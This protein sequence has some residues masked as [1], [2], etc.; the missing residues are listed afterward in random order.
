MEVAKIS[1]FPNWMQEFR[2]P[3]PRWT[4]PDELKRPTPSPSINLA[5]VI[6]ASRNIGN[7]LIDLIG[8]W[9]SV[10]A[11]LNMWY[12]DPGRRDLRE[13][14]YPKLLTA[15]GNVAGKV[16][17]SW[18]AYMRAFD[19]P[20]KGFGESEYQELLDVVRGGTLEIQ[21]LME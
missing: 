18:N 3:L 5:L 2:D 11:R 1:E 21:A 12:K 14:E 6:L 4:P 7:D 10:T 9:I 16:F 8:S 20:S 17:H 15:Q 19:D 13:G